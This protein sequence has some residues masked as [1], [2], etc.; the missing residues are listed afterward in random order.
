[1]AFNMDKLEQQRE[2]FTKPKLAIKECNKRLQKQ[3]KDPY[4]LA[5][6]F[7]L[8][9]K[10][11]RDEASAICHN[12]CNRTPPIT[13]SRLLW[14][15]YFST[16]DA[17]SF[18]RESFNS[19]GKDLQA[20]WLNAAKTVKRKSEKG[21]IF[22]TLFEL[23]ARLD[24]W[25]DAQWALLNLR[26]EF[27]DKSKYFFSYII[28]TQLSAQKHGTLGQTSASSLA[29]N[30]AYRFLSNAI[31][32]SSVSLGSPD[33][34]ST[35]RELRLV[36]QVYRKQ[37]RGKEL[38]DLLTN[39]DNQVR[40]IMDKNPLEF[41]RIVLDTMEEERM[42][43][44]LWDYCLGLLPQSMTSGKEKNSE[45]APKGTIQAATDW[46]IWKCL[47]DAT[48][49]LPET[50][51]EFMTDN[52]FCLFLDESYS[53]PR[54]FFSAW[55][56]FAAK[57]S[58][59][60][61]LL[62]ICQRFW[63][64]F[65]TFNCCFDDLRYFVEMLEPKNRKIFQSYA[66]NAARSA[67]PKVDEKQSWA[68]WLQAEINA[69]K[70]DYL[71]SI[72]RPKRPK[73]NILEKFIRTCLLIYQ[74]GDRFGLENHHDTG[75][76]AVMGLVKLHYVDIQ[77]SKRPSQRFLLQAASLLRS[78]T[79][80]D[81]GNQNRPIVL[82]S[83]RL[84][85]LLGLGSVALAQYSQVR[86]KE[87]LHET[88]SHLLLTR[89]S[90]THPFD[91]K[92]PSSPRTIQPD[93]E[94]DLAIRAFS[95]TID[96]LNDFLGHDFEMFHYDQTSEICDLK[97]RLTFSL[98]KHIWI[99][100]RRRIARLKGVPC[101]EEDLDF[102]E[103]NLDNLFDHRDFSVIPNF[104]SSRS[105]PFDDF[106]S[107]NSYPGYD[108]FAHFAIV[109]ETCSILAREPAMISSTETRIGLIKNARAC[110]QTSLTPFEGFL[111]T[112]WH[113]LHIITSEVVQDQKPAQG[114]TS[115]MV[116]DL[117]QW[118]TS[119]RQLFKTWF[120]ESE[121]SEASADIGGK[122]IMP[123]AFLQHGF[124][125]LEVLQAAIKLCDTAISYLKQ[126][127]HPLKENLTKG[128]VEKV[129]GVIDDIYASI[130]RFAR[131]RVD[132]VRRDGVKALAAQLQYGPTGEALRDVLTEG[133]RAV[134]PKE[135]ANSAEDAWTGILKVKLR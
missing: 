68:T 6:K 135:Y 33:K 111:S 11:D 27:P 63:D 54:E 52:I 114:T 38:V 100:E 83:I 105:P 96:K 104:E 94:L 118:L 64:R 115:Q 2:K 73:K 69:L 25:E 32:N 46:K 35:A 61:P 126:K 43:A 34:I 82:L 92:P 127:S 72:S 125:C 20:L 129:M 22:H 108:W 40:P 80:G 50:R 47:M 93:S 109:D 14:Y 106:L 21:H 12:L 44:S 18:Y 67:S 128:D 51:K 124:Q 58:K 88:I 103:R 130:Q 16:C 107:P 90:V 134:F 49:H 13:D 123:S 81:K 53:P 71:L 132:V 79:S 95:R 55:M 116:E 28:A 1:M 15:I 9:G 17:K 59:A 24:C 10:A 42:W 87:I 66:S 29:S 120:I 60:I 99:L 112:G 131:N 41:T 133:E 84:H 121:D 26:K 122:Y 3:P 31:K 86:T 98:V 65:Y 75:V 56:T 117:R 85:T 78:L 97:N 113:L 101:D 39:P 45:E 62:Q 4:L 8:L 89:I 36:C 23:A 7:E 70:F 110:P 119:L 48:S 74:V 77:T 30:L 91:S 102:V 19:A 76:L 37:G 57:Y 5:W